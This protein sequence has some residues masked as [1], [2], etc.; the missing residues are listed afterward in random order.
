MCCVLVHTLLGLSPSASQTLNI[1]RDEKM[2]GLL[3]AVHAVLF[4]FLTVTTVI[5]VFFSM[6]LCF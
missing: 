5:N 1:S 2:W 3:S 4:S 6:S